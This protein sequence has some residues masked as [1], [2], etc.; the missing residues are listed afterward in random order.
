[1]NTTQE[2]IIDCLRQQLDY[3]REQFQVKRIG[4]FGSFATETAT[5]HSD[6]DLVIEFERPI[7][8]KFVNL[9]DYLEACLGRKVDVL[10]LAGIATIRNRSV[11]ES[12]TRS[13]V[14]V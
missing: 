14:Y 3:L 1:M 9:C 11:A 7:G 6:V 13:L 5:A 12:I 8:L 2:A 10:T 4:L